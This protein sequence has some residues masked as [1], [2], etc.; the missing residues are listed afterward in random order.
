MRNM[1]KYSGQNNQ[2][3]RNSE[4]NEMTESLQ[5]VEKIQE[6]AL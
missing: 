2:I 4:A 6:R 5:K 3:Q 1:S